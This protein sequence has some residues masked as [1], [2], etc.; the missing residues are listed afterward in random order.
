MLL[1]WFA[2]LSFSGPHSVRTVHHDP[3]GLWMLMWLC[4]VVKVKFSAVKNNIAWEP[5][6]LGP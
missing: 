3:S 6:M 2:I 1:E 5:G 4:L